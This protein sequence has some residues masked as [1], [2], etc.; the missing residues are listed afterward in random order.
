MV[1]SSYS[2]VLLVTGGSGVTF[3][4]GQAEELIQ[5]ISAGKSS[6]KFIELIWVTQEKGKFHL[7]ISLTHLS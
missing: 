6:V 3:G 4:I 7:T 5:Q 2:S 1:M